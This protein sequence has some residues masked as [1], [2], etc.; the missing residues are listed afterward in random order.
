MQKHPA[1]AAVPLLLHACCGPCATHCIGELR[2]GG[3]QP[4]LCYANDNLADAA[5]YE[6]RL[7]ALR[8][9]AEAEEVELLVVEYDHDAWLESIEGLETEPEGGRRCEA[10]FRHNFRR[11]L[12]LALERGYGG[13]ASTLTVSPHKRSV[14]VFEAG[15]E[16]AESGGDGDSGDGGSGVM[17]AFIECDF[18]KR[19]GFRQSLELTRKYGLYRQSFCGC[20][21]SRR[22]GKR[23]MKE[24]G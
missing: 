11:V 1:E 16:V 3:Y 23:R 7:A 17:P 8:K 20:E 19:D 22:E 24:E 6:K 4:V 18:K 2:R 12:Q 5:E 14:Q 21:F 10:C 9:L 15:R 13:F